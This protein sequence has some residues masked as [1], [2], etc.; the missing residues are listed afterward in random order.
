MG[1]YRFIPSTGIND[2]QPSVLRGDPNQL[3][4]SNSGTRC[5]FMKLRGMH[6]GISRILINNESLACKSH[7][8]R[9]CQE[10]KTSHL[11]IK[12]TVWSLLD[13]IAISGMLR[14]TLEQKSVLTIAIHRIQPKK[15][16]WMTSIG[17]GKDPNNLE[18]E[19]I[20]KF[21]IQSSGIS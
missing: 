5:R 11:I 12:I 6:L 14:R 2:S 16:V 20:N 3:L 10:R 4:L 18:Y 17:N 9:C 15:Y 21:L 19:Y 7:V 8:S 13:G 1:R